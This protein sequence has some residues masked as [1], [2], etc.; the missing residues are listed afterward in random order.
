MLKECSLT[1][2]HMLELDHVRFYTQESLSGLLAGQFSRWRVEK[3]EPI[4]VQRLLPWYIRKPV[5]LLIRLGFYR[6][7]IYFRLYAEAEI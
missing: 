1:Y 3:G 2:E 6:S 4:P 5:S 7:L